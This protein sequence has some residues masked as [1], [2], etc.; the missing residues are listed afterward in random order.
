MKTSRIFHTGLYCVGRVA[1]LLAMLT[2]SAGT[3]LAVDVVTDGDMEAVGIVAWPHSDI[4]DTNSSAKA[5]D[6]SASGQSLKGTSQVASKINVGWYNAQTVGLVNSADQVFLSLWWAGQMSHTGGGN[7]ETLALDVKTT[8]GATWSTAWSIALTT[9]QTSVQTGTV[10]LLDISGFFPTSESYDIRLRTEGK[11]GNNNSAVNYSWFDNVV[12]DVTGV[13]APPT[14]IVTNP[15]DG[16]NTGGSGPYSVTGTASDSDG[17]VTQVRLEIQRQ[18]NSQYWNGTGWQAG[19][20]WLTPT[21]GGGWATW[22]YS[23]AWTTDLEGVAVN[24]TAEATDDSAATR[25]DTHGCTVDSWAPRIATGVRLQTLPTSDDANF[26]LLSD[27]TEANPGTPRFDYS[28]NAAGYLGFAA[29]SAGNTSSRTF[30]V[31]LDGDDDFVA[32]KSDHT[33]S[34]GNGPIQSEDT[35]VVYVL[36]LTP[37]APTVGGA[38]VS[39]LDVTI[40]A[41]G[42]EGGVGMF[43]AIRCDTTGEYVQADSTLGVSPVWRTL[44]AWGTPVTVTGL[45]AS[46][47]FTFSTAAGNPSDATPTTGERS[48]SAFGTGADGTTLGPPEVTTGA[49]THSQTGCDFTVSSAF[50]GDGDSDSSTA[51]QA[52]QSSNCNGGGYA[53]IGCDSLTGV[54]PRECTDSG[55]TPSADYCYLVTYTDDPEG[56]LGTNPIQY[57]PINTGA[58]GG[59]PTTTVGDGTNPGNSDLC[60]GADAQVDGFS[61]QTDTGAD[62]VTDVQVTLAGE[63]DIFNRVSSVAITS[64]DGLT[65]YGTAAAAANV[66]NINLSSTIG[67]STTL[68]S[69]RV[70]ITAG[71]H[72]SLINPTHTVTATVTDITVTDGKTIS[73][74]TSSTVTIDNQV[75]AASWGVVTP[76]DTQVSLAWSNP[77]DPD[78][79]EVIIVRSTNPVTFTPIDG[80]TYNFNDVVDAGP[81]QQIVRYVGNGTATTDTGLTNGVVYHYAIFARDAC[82]NWSSADT[83]GPHTPAVGANNEVTT[84][85]P[86]G[87][88]DGCTQI[89]I[90]CPFSDDDNSNS[91]TTV[92]RGLAAVG[93]FTVTV[94]TGLTGASPRS[95]VDTS[96]SASTTYYYEVTFAD[97][98]GVLGTNPRV[99]ADLTTPACGVDDT[100]P[101]SNSATATSCSQITLTSHFTGDA[102]SDGSTLVEYLDGVWKTACAAATG[103]SPRQCIIPGLAAS[104]AYDV[105]ITHSD[106]D[107][108]NIAGTPNPETLSAV[109]T[110]ACGADQTP[111]TALVVSPTREAIIGGPE[112]VKIHV[113]EINLQSVL[114]SVDGNPFTA[115]APSGTYAACGTDC[116]VY[117]WNLDTTALSNGEHYLTVRVQD[118]SNNLD[119]VS[120]PFAVNNIGSS[121]AGNGYLLRRTHSSQLCLDCHNVATHSSQSTGSKYG[122]WA[123]DCL[124]CHTPHQTE[125]IYIVRETIK[126][127]NSGSREVIFTAKGTGTDYTTPAAPYKGA[128][129]VCHTR[130]T[131]HRGDDSGGDH[132]HNETAACTDCHG[133]DAGFAGSGCNGCHNAPPVAIGKHSMHDE[134]WDSVTTTASSYS[135]AASHGD[136]TRYGFACAK[137]HSGT[138]TNDATNNPTHDGSLANPWLVEVGFDN[139]TDPKNP[140]GGYAGVYDE[141]SEGGGATPSGEYW[142][143]SDGTCSNLYCH[144]DA[145]PLPTDAPT[146]KSVTWD[147]VAGLDCTGCHDTGGASSSL[148]PAHRLHTDGNKYGFGCVRCHTN[149]VSGDSTV[150]DKTLHVNGARN[151]DFDSSGPDNSGAGYD[152]GAYTCSNTYCHSDGTDQTPDYTSGSSIAWTASGDCRSC[153]GGDHQAAPIMSSGKHSNH[154]NN[155]VAVGTRYGCITCHD[156]TV[157]SNTTI[158]NPGGWTTH[159]NGTSNVSMATGTWTDPTCENTACHNSGQATPVD[160]PPNWLADALDCK[161]CHGRFL[162]ADFVS[163]A[164]EPNYANGGGGTA[165]ANSHGKHVGANTDCATCHNLTVGGTP[166]QISGSDPAQHIDTT[167]DVAIIAAYDT[168]GATS[169]YDTGSKTCNSVSCHGAGTPQWGGAL[170]CGDCHLATNDVDD[171]NITNGTMATISSSEWSGRGH[172]GTTGNL[173]FPGGNP[174]L[175]CH[176]DGVLHGDGANPFRLANFDATDLDTSDDPAKDGWNSVCLIC[177]DSNGTGY[178]PGSGLIT[179]SVAT[180]TIDAYHFGTDHGVGDG[181]RLCWDCHDPHGDDSNIKMIGDFLIRGGSDEYGLVATRTDVAAVFTNNTNGSDWATSSAPF[182][183]VCN[184]CHTDSGPAGCDTGNH[185]TYDNDGSLGANG[186]GDDHN[187]GTVCTTCHGHDQPPSDAFRGAGGGDCLSSGCHG[188]T[189]TPKRQV[190]IDFANGT[191]PD[192]RSH[193]VGNGLT[194]GGTL[195]NFDCVVCHAEGKVIAG[196]DTD[197]TGQPHMDGI[198]NL[199]DTDDATAY[200]DYD[201][202]SMPAAAA[203]WNSANDTW[204]TQTS[205]NLDPFCLTCHDSN[206]ASVTFAADGG[207]ADALNPFGDA[208][209]TNNYDQLVRGTG[210]GRVVDIAS[211]VV[212]NP[213]PDGQFARHAIRGQSPSHNSEYDAI[214]GGTS[215]FDSGVMVSVAT[216]FGEGPL[217]NDTSVMGCADCHTTDGANGSAGN[218]H[219]S[220]SEY[221]LKDAS[222]GATQGTFGGGSYICFACH[223]T[224]TYDT[225]H[226]GGN[227]GDFAD[228][229]DKA[230]AD[231]T[232]TKNDGSYTGIACINC[233]GGAPG[234]GEPVSKGFGRIHGTSSVFDVGSGGTRNTYRFTNGGS[235]RFFDPKGWTSSGAST[236]ACYTL[237]G[238]DNWGGCTAHVGAQNKDGDRQIARPITY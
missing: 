19:Q 123:V 91:T 27:W 124:T 17:T 49:V 46:T 53:S 120:Q 152:Y 66:V 93:P 43:Y 109:T 119:I 1:L 156:A 98:D 197:T 14:A 221:L 106:P 68:E 115:A 28:L 63:A 23:W 214:A 234:N 47:L 146:Y 163:I 201:K 153:H 90:S 177:H 31:A 131:H 200:F 71:S 95:C 9:T 16:S 222:G 132:T 65:V 11:T 151:V 126:T 195:T 80:T 203:N 88:V 44:A 235:L 189:S 10:V 207:T 34:Y 199:R 76:G 105:R 57:G 138:H 87:V 134:V 206:G 229:T 101:T 209:I 184:I 205:T 108:I 20:V 167:R 107:G 121:P 112:V 147:Q 174:C 168:N 145:D 176:T 157:E 79:A 198:I 225:T 6:Q 48:A 110:L 36:P 228:T 171:W 190:D 187:I 3:A 4:T 18:D 29:G 186:C 100:T 2:L 54:S 144:S 116:V 41:N 74:T 150:S 26:T 61:L 5:T 89:T 51:I 73:D 196:P 217:W 42:A 69:Y 164:G 204:R 92:K 175:Y 155:L 75:G 220:S 202:R 237:S 117:E 158:L 128:C 193:H 37:P 188:G 56:V 38:T 122:S 236:M 139:T 161:G 22:S 15:A 154:I 125:N 159:V 52:K 103:S 96:A 127:P 129:E 24:I 160:Y 218:A 32:I 223:V 182:T 135:D 45:S 181:G 194:M 215:L 72:A 39:S 227:G 185:Y 30:A 35:T 113:F 67:V 40:N 233:H 224:A 232:A 172:G 173:P 219:G 191:D 212:G 55:L 210:N 83:T 149:T 13:N 148:S 165:T 33:D 162:P 137:C 62:T 85:S 180:S 102:N 94:C 231:R 12:L 211:M 183:K 169:N 97:A 178:D 70:R 111:P 7:N 104:T 58:C 133:H 81:P 86:T 208:D 226:T 130:T 8:A 114:V 84:G 230:G 216:D 213:P 143:Y 64:I 82:G 136:A 141:S 99:T 25:T 60:P 140:S 179:V 170:T 142:S 238:N 118:T 21:N 166:D 50:T 78:F 59:T 77:A 192:F